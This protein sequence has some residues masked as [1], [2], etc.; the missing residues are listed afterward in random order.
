M[1]RLVVGALLFCTLA[2]GADKPVGP[3][4][5]VAGTWDATAAN[6]AAVL[7]LSDSSVAPYV[8]GTAYFQ[9][10]AGTTGPAPANDVIFDGHVFGGIFGTGVHS[11]TINCT[12][13]SNGACSGTMR[14][15]SAGAASGMLMVRR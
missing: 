15:G 7:T 5:G 8:T 12:M 2:C 4:R 11:L 14:I 1:R 3:P 6:A 9:D 13:Q 10:N